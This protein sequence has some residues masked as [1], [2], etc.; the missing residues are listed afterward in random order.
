MY[1]KYRAAVKRLDRNNAELRS[2]RAKWR[3]TRCPMLKSRDRRGRS[4]LFGL[5]IFAFDHA[6]PLPDAERF[7]F[8][9][10]RFYQNAVGG[11]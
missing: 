4:R 6:Q 8:R 1:L 9:G 5:R 7:V 3:V 11:R 2:F 10:Q